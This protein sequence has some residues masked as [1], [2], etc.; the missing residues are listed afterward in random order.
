MLKFILPLF[1]LLALSAVAYQPENKPPNAWSVITTP[2]QGTPNAIGG[3]ANGCMA[4]AERLP[5]SGQG[6]KDMRRHRGRYYGQPELIAFIKALG[7]YTAKRHG[8]K[9]LI[10]DLSQ[11]R[12][13][14]M[15]F[16][17]SSHQIG[18]DVDIWM[19]TVDSKSPVNPY[20]DMQSI[21]DKAGGIIIGAKIPTATRDALYFSATQ[22]N[23]ARIFVNPVVKWHLCQ[24]ETDT[25]WLRKIRPWW[26]H[27]QHFHVRL[28]C[29]PRSQQCKNQKPPPPGDGC[30]DALYR[31]VDEQSGLATGRIKPKPQVKKKR[32]QKIPPAAC[33]WLQSE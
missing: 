3:Y 1:S 26:G 8:K 23:V 10:G 32:P 12:G 2:T 21:V 22:P 25:G 27:N 18:L 6:F 16:G 20:R 30:N 31:W 14:K 9:H 29:P 11:A 13:G 17:H 5:A 19:Q 28:A 24:S 7:Q 15:N 4:G 33:Q